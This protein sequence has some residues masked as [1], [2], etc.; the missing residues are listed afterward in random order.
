MS[1]KAQKIS[2]SDFDSAGINSLVTTAKRRDCFSY[3]SVFNRAATDAMENGEA[4]QTAVYECFARATAARLVSDK[5]HDPFEPRSAIEQFTDDQLDFLAQVS[6]AIP[7]AE[8]RARVA[9]IVWVLKRNAECA[10]LAVESYLVAA[11]ALFDPQHWPFYADRI[12]RALRL[13]L[14][15]ND[16]SLFG[17]II[18]EIENRL[19]AMKGEDPKY[20]SDKLMGFLLDVGEG[21]PLTYS[22][23][24]RKAAA[25][26]EASDDLLRARAYLETAAKWEKKAG[27]PGEERDARIKAAETYVSEADQKLAKGKGHLV[28]SIFIGKAVEAYRRIGGEQDRVDELHR[29]MLAHQQQ[30]EGEMKKF[31]WRYD[32]SQMAEESRKTV[33]GLPLE[34]ALFNLAFCTES[35]NVSD[36]R[37]HV[38]QNIQHFPLQHLTPAYLLDEKNRTM[39]HV[40]G[41]ALR[42]GEEQETLIRAKMHQEAGIHRRIKLGGTILPIRDQINLEHPVDQESFRQFV[43]HNPFVPPGRELLFERGLYA[44]ITDDF[45]LAGHILIP[46]FE[47]SIRHLLEMKGVLTSTLDSQGIQEDRTL[48]AL[49]YREETEEIFGQSTLFDLQGLL[50]ERPGANLRNRMAHGLMRHDEFFSDEVIYLWWLTLRIICTPFVVNEDHQDREEQ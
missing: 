33:A 29:Q 5:P 34:S 26:A 22:A 37:D 16:R 42:D 9:D 50:V 36:L 38:K 47:E 12:E 49:I 10:R 18:G 13:V 27:R 25:L 11:D 15:I 7:D 44:G 45:V 30:C 40:P 8:L 17:K 19:S 35:A 20:L 39:A 14:Q 43:V 31:G 2:K 46:Q 28:T 23:L 32:V 41:A 24:A 3:F 4:V 48:G 6:E 1:N 21:D